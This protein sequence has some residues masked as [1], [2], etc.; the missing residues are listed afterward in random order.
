MKNLIT[1]I[2]ILIAFCATGITQNTGIGT[3]TPQATLD[4]NGTFKL[5][6]GV[7][8]N[9][10]SNDTTFEQASDSILPTQLAVKKYL[11]QGRWVPGFQAPDSTLVLRDSIG[12]QQTLIWV[13]VQGNYA[14]AIRA[15]SG[16]YIYDI[17]NPDSIQLRGSTTTNINSPQRVC[18]QGDYAYVTSSVNNQLN[19]YNISN[20][21]NIIALGTTNQNLSGPWGLF[22]EGN[23]AYVASFNNDRLCIFN[24]SNPNAITAVSYTTNANMDGPEMVWKQNNFISY[25]E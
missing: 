15:L 21:D 4:V 3:T 25:Q 11:Q 1:T 22:V 18:V 7:T 5:Q 10:I 19:I 16:L 2:L 6:Q 14:Y 9:T 8:T 23:Y 17:T 20:P 13:D 12:N 24:I